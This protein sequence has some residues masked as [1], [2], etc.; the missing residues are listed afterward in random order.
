MPLAVQCW[1]ASWQFSWPV[2]L[3][4][5]VASCQLKWCTQFCMDFPFLPGFIFNRPGVAGAVLQTASWFVK[6]VSHCTLW[7]YLPPDIHNIIN[8]KPLELDSWN[9]ER[10]F[11]LYH[12][13][14]VTW[15]VSPV[16]CH[17]SHVTC[18]V[19]PVTCHMSFVFCLFLQIGGTSRWRVC[20][21]RGLPCLIFHCIGL[22]VDSVYKS[23]CPSVCCAIRWD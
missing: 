13:S 2:G 15:H 21:Q 8:P 12:V 11:T 9:F 20:Y 1:S 16:T 18:H 10:M 19:S 6:S 5:L 23:Q 17:V 7:K 3:A 4:C 14:C 22:G